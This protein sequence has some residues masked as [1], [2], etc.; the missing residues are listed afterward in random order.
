MAVREQKPEEMTRLKLV[1]LWL[2][3]ALS[4]ALIWFSALPPQSMR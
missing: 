3:V 4:I 2:S 1:L